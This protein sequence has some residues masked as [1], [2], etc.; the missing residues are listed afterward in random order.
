[1]NIIDLYFANHFHQNNN[2]KSTFISN[3]WYSVKERQ[4]HWLSL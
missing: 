1:M 3:M 4:L 2:K